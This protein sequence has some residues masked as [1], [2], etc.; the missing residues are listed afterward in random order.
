MSKNKEHIKSYNFPI[1]LYCH[2]FNDNPYLV[3]MVD[4]TNIMNMVIFFLP[5]LRNCHIMLQ[6]F[7]LMSSYSF[8]DLLQLSKIMGQGLNLI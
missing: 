1:K 8:C 2:Y 5:K 4:L 3:N 7:V 6:C